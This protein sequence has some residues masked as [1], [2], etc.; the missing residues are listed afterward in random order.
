MPKEDA[1]WHEAN[2]RQVIE[3]G[4]ALEFEEYSQLDDRSITWLTTKFP[5][6]DAQEKIYA[7]GGI[8]ADISDRKKAEQ[9][10][11]ENQ[12]RLVMI[13][14]AADIGLWSLDTQTKA[15]Y[16]DQ[17]T[18][19]ILGLDD[20]QLLNGVALAARIHPE[21]LVKV[22]GLVERIQREQERLEVEFRMNLAGGNQHW[23]Y[24]RGQGI[25]DHEGQSKQLVGVVM[26]ITGRR[27]L[28]EQVQ[29][30]QARLEVQR[31]LLEQR[32]QERLQI[33][34][35]LHD[36]PM[37]E[38]LGAIYAIQG[39]IA[40]EADDHL[41][42]GLRAVVETLHTQ[43]SELRTYASELR[44]PTLAQFGLAKAIQSHIESYQSK[45][46]NIQVHLQV[47]QSEEL[48]PEN[49][50]LGLFRIYQ[51]AMNNIAKHCQKAEVK[52]TFN[53]MDGIARLKITDDGP[54]FEPPEDWLVQARAGHLGLVG[55]RERAEAI[56]GRLEIESTPGRGTTIRVE[57]PLGEAS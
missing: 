25:F 21:D 13:T 53:K 18:K 15:L 19:A 42:N 49:I 54:G 47:S 26:D 4:K 11:K 24:M 45:H 20:T 16:L 40:T 23:L 5:L 29:V 57:V 14:E 52:V 8:S 46:P 36:G 10:L 28:M 37:Q 55:M 38:I 48:T 34:R 50:R 35:E 41:T 30:D 12:E 31:R 32:E 9:A 27:Q 7:V 6:R 3:A 1:D 2:D 44:P 56:G 33:A 43:L 22:E 17:Q 51:E 39:M